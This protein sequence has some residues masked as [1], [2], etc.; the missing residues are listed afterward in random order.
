[1][2]KLALAA[3]L[4]ALAT[5][6]WAANDETPTVTS[7]PVIICGSRGQWRLTFAAA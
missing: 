3:L 6:A 1:M 5:P 2:R 7:G 4:V